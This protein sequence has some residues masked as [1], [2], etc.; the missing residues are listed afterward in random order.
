[1]TEIS[2]NWTYSGA[3]VKKKE[4]EIDAS[5]KAREKISREDYLH[6]M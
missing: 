1:M 6:L 4:K 5:V 2:F 3:D